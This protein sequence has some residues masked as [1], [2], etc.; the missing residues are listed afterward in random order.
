MDDSMREEDHGKH[1]ASKSLEQIP[2]SDLPQDLDPIWE[3][4]ELDWEEEMNEQESDQ[5]DS[6]L[7]LI[8]VAVLGSA[9]KDFK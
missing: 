9:R 3:D 8:C 1:K 7:P 5:K 6:H 2:N 4:F